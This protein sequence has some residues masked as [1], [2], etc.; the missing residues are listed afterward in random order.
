MQG[1][2]RK[3]RAPACD[4]VEEIAIARADEQRTCRVGFDRREC[5]QCNPACVDVALACGI[6]NERRDR[7]DQAS[8]ERGGLERTQLQRLSFDRLR[9]EKAP[10]DEAPVA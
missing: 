2:G 3:T 5:P 10:T 1:G 9:G 6:A 7:I 4:R 8:V